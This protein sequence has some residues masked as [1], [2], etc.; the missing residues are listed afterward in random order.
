VG[1]EILASQATLDAATEVRFG[2]SEPR[3]LQLKGV[4]EPMEVRAV[5]W[6]A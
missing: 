4:Q 6:R 5:E 3:S 2:L 1:E